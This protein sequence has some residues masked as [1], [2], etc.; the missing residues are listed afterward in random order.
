MKAQLAGTR[1]G[2]RIDEDG[3]LTQGEPGYALTW[4]DARVDGVGVTPRIGKPV[5]LNALWIHG[6]AAIG[7]L[8]TARFRML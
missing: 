5:E 7:R 1:Y 8:T 3:L 2:I 6:L 4:M